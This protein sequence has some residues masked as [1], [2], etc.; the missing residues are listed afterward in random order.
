MNPDD[1]TAAFSTDD[2]FVP[3]VPEVND[4]S[5]DDAADR[6]Y[7]LDDE[8]PAAVPFGGID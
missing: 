8:Y 2:E 5:P 6:E 3:G 4:Y 1:D 7:P